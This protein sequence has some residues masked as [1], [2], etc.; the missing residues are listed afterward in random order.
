MNYCK[1]GI[2]SE[3]ITIHCLQ[4][5]RTAKK[6]NWTVINTARILLLIEAKLPLS[7]WAEVAVYIYIMCIETAACIYSNSY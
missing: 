1:K 2:K 3:R 5:N 4:S 6:A 7:F